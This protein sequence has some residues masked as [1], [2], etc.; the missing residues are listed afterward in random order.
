[1][2][3][4]VSRPPSPSPAPEGAPSAR[5]ITPD[6]ILPPLAWSRPARIAAAVAIF[7]VLL[8]VAIFDWSVHPAMASANQLAQVDDD[9]IAKRVAITNVDSIDAANKALVHQWNQAPPLPQLP[10]PQS[11]SPQSPRPQSAGPHVTACAVD[12]LGNKQIACVLLDHD[13]GP[14]VMT[15]AR[16]TDMAMPPVPIITQGQ[17]T[18]GVGSVNGLNMVLL[19]QGGNW[20]CLMGRV[21]QPA[22]LNLAGALQF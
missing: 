9:L 8:A 18:C 17:L 6:Q 5:P 13:N 10:I 15:V 16:L 20:V 19:R 11:S 21:S 14:V 3:Q 22:L 7:V 4:S 12:A 1:M 2:T